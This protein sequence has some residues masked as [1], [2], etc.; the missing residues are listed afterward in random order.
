MN[1]GLNSQNSFV[2]NYLVLDLGIEHSLALEERNQR[3][4]IISH[5]FLRLLRLLLNLFFIC[6]RLILML[7]KV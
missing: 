2:L 4:F 7:F 1:S 3:N 5:T 6:R